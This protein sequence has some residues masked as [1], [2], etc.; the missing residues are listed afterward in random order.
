MG[1]AYGGAIVR[2]GLV[3]ALDAA[4]RNSY[5]GTG[6]TWYDL[7]GNN[8]DF[9]LNNTPTYS[10][11]N[12]GIFT[13]D[14]V[15]DYAEANT[16]KVIPDTGPFSVVFAFALTGTGGRGGVFERKTS[17]PYNGFSLGQGGGDNWG[18]TVSSTATSSN[19][20]FV[21]FTYPTTNVFYIDT[22]TFN[23]S[24]TLKGYRN[25]ALVDTDTDGNQ[26]NLSTQGTRQNLNI[27]RRDTVSTELP[28]KVGCVQVYTTELSATE[29]LQNYNALKGRFGL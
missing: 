5:P 3:L 7:S 22:V 21:Y 26:G 8:E 1:L 15:D 25:G 12:N 16:A 29:V 20:L 14:G 24:N 11:T 9:T 10:S 2:D 17:S 13:F 27:A 19:G 6:T 28:C 23:G 18:G 4:D